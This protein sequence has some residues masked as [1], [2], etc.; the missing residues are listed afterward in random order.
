[1]TVGVADAVAVVATAAAARVVALAVGTRPWTVTRIPLRMNEPSVSD[2]A[3]PGSW[4]ISMMRSLACSR[5]WRRWHP[6][7][8]F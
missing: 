2:A 6:T 7:A 4:M 1:M 8:S 3:E 5:S